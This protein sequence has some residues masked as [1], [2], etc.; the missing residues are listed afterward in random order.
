MVLKKPSTYINV[1]NDENWYLI[2][3]VY[4]SYNIGSQVK[5]NNII[6]NIELR[7]AYSYVPIYPSISSTQFRNITG[8]F[9][10]QRTPAN[11]LQIYNYLN[12]L[13]EVTGGI[14]TE[15]VAR[16][17]IRLFIKLTTPVIDILEKKVSSPYI[18]FKYTNKLINVRDTAEIIL[19][20]S[21][22]EFTITDLYES[23]II[24]SSADTILQFQ[25]YQINKVIIF[26]DNY[27]YKAG[28]K[29]YYKEAANSHNLL[30]INTRKSNNFLTINSINE[31]N[32]KGKLYG[33]DI[34][35]N[36]LI[37]SD[38]T[39]DANK[40]GITGSLN[41]HY[42]DGITYNSPA[43]DFIGLSDKLWAFLTY[44]NKLQ[45]ASNDNLR[46]LYFRNKK[47]NTWKQIISAS[48]CNI[49]DYKDDD[50]TEFG[51][52]SLI[53]PAYSITE[54]QADHSKRTITQ[55][56]ITIKIPAGK[57][58]DGS[59]GQKTLS[60]P[61]NILLS[62]PY[63]Q[64]NQPWTISQGVSSLSIEC[65]ILSKEQSNDAYLSIGG[66]ETARGGDYIITIG[67]DKGG[68]FAKINSHATTYIGSK[69]NNKNFYVYGKIYSSGSETIEGSADYAE[70]FEWEDSNPNNEDRV[71]Y[72]VSI[73]SNRKIQIANTSSY[74][75]GIVSATPAVIGNGAELEWNKKYLT[76]EWGRPIYE[77]VVIPAKYDE[78][79]K[80][81][82]PEH[83]EKRLKL[84][85]DYDESIKY[86][87]RSERPEWTVVGMLG[88]LRVRDDGSC[89][90]G[91]Y[92]NVNENGIATASE[93]GYYVTKRFSDNII[94]VFFK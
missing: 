85:P 40:I 36:R 78:S 21:S 6:H 52:T 90:V 14:L 43:N 72:F 31:V 79:G 67:A 53:L 23:N 46:D 42:I 87:P 30:N 16:P 64:N 17:K 12:D 54:F 10:A 3:S 86:I 39:S 55:E 69:N 15:G 38:G 41:I 2:D 34:V 57:K 24:S 71:G 83:A 4:S 9:T 74:I 19:E 58:Y 5:I 51:T 70:Y 47:N 22:C 82:E 75:L 18:Y 33:N 63:S 32:V 29:I 13:L 11:E 45:L 84:N 93:S 94:E 60:I 61:A 48:V 35:G 66:N 25:L 27:E 80:E 49:N 81:I 7:D 8:K 92:C 50:S 1:S 37:E 73:T 68:S 62:N 91:G 65:P 77:T 26:K 56:N 76:D 59:N 89:K 88:M 44:D 20:K 28:D